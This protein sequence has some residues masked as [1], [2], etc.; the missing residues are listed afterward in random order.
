[1][2]SYAGARDVLLAELCQAEIEH[3][4]EIASASLRLEHNVLW[5]EVAVNDSERVC[6]SESSQHLTQDIDDACKREFTFLVCDQPEVFPSEQ[7]HHE[8]RLSVVGATEVK[9]G[10]A[11]GVIQLACRPCFRQEPERGVFI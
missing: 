1:R 8:V 5:F 6:F 3:L 9:H 10:D 7:F 4:D 11:V 2:A